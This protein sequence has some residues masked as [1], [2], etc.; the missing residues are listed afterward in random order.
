MVPAP[1]IM[2]G[3]SRLVDEDRVDLV[4]DREGVSALHALASKDDHVV[5]QVVEAEL[6]VGAVGDVGLVCRNA[7]GRVHLR[8][9][10]A[11][12]HAEEPV[13]LA[14]PL[15]VALGQVVVDSDD[16]DASARQCIAVARE[17]G[18]ERLTLAR[19]HL[20]DHAVVEDH[21]ADHLDVEVAHAQR[22]DGR[23]ARDGVGLRHDVGE[24]LTVVETVAK[25]DGLVREL[26]IGQRLH[27]GLELVDVADE[28]LV[29]AKLPPLT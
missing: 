25:L 15:A 10:D 13:D 12:V 22:A 8:L 11:D 7:L 27:P 26:R 16:V 17:R 28:L 6:R 5:A 3:S 20:G 18:D 4:D 1:E 19:L 9:D 24:F 14:H 29:S 2:R 21:R 23:L